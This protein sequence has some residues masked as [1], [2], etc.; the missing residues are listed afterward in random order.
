MVFVHGTASS[1]VRWAEMIN[2]LDSDPAIREHFEFW[3]FSYPTGVPVL[4]SAN[5]LRGWLQRVVAELDPDGTDESLR[6]M[7]LVG[8]SQGGLIS[9]LQ[10]I[11]SGSRFWDD[12]S[13]VPFDRVELRPE[14]RTLLEGA[15]FFEPSPY[16]SSVIFIATPKRGSFLA[17]N[18]PGRLATRLTQAPGHLVS[19]PLDLAR[20]G[21]A[22]PGMAVDLVTGEVDELRVQ[23]ALGRIPTSV[24]NMNPSSSFIRTLADIR[25]EPPV[26][27]HSIIPVTGGP[28]PDG[29]D[30]GVVSFESA[31]TEEA[32]SELVIFNA[33]H[34]VQANPEAIQE[35]RRILL[36][37]I[38]EP[39]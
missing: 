33:G 14:T 8:H 36:E 23:R 30:D 7:V 22:L 26:V 20:A 5:L 27:A 9:K 15:L 21:V 17:A 34:S 29:Q 10:V 3:F 37:R 24:D 4:Y 38:G 6:K 39:R 28:P 25:I 12:V 19:L 31:R 16:V 32:Q 13:D 11:S 1:V 35:V 2:E 18:W